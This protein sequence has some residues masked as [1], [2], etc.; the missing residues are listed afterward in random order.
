[1]TLGG[2]I[3]VFPE[4]VDDGAPVVRLAGTPAA[5]IWMAEKTGTLALANLASLPSYTTAIVTTVNT[6]S[7]TALQGQAFDG[8]VLEFASNRSDGT[9]PTYSATINWGDG[10]TTP[11]IVRPTNSGT[12]TVTGSNTYTLAP[13]STA[14]VSVTVTDG[15]G[16]HAVLYNQVT[17]QA[18]PASTAIPTPA[19]ARA[20]RAQSVAAH[21]SAAITA[22]HQA[23]AVHPRGPVHHVSSRVGTAKQRR[24]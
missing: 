16:G 5:T 22:A 23:R 3:T 2:Q 17:I 8:T 1:M 24:R 18:A 11:G 10:H 21:R 9:A 4:T 20:L 13:N 6:S 15:K 14:T 7:F 12:F 19:A